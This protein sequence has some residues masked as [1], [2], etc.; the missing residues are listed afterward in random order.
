M[1]VEKD[2]SYLIANN[3]NALASKLSFWY[4]IATPSE[5]SAINIET[6]RNGEWATE[7]SIEAS[8]KKKETMTIDFEPTASEGFRSN[9]RARQTC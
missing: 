4:Y 9:E 3:S 8:T 5:G 7:Q 1:K 6:M 2:G